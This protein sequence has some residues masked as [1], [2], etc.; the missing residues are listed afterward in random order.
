V[1]VNVEKVA[2]VERAEKVV[3][4]ERV[5]KVEKIAN[6]YVYA[7]TSDRRGSVGVLNSPTKL[8]ASFLR[9]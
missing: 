6:K 9:E 2:K 1:V 5:V 8:L 7:R 3:K 4:V